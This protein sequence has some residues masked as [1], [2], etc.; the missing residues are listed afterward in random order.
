MPLQSGP[1]LRT[2]S[3]YWGAGI[4]SAPSAKPLPMTA[5]PNGKAR[6]DP[7]LTRIGYAEPSR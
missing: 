7:K 2:H 6:L 5:E 4:E 3:N 1:G